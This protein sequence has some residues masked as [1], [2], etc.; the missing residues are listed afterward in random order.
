MRCFPD[1]SSENQEDSDEDLALLATCRAPQSSEH[2]AH[3]Q[4]HLAM[5]SL[6]AG[7][8]HSVNGPFM[9]SALKLE[10]EVR[11]QQPW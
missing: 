11:A 6:L 4:S 10:R 1:P 2:A 3:R 8:Y 7:F 5:S 9:Q